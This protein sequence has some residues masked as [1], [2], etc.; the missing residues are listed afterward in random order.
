MRAVRGS[1][2]RRLSLS[3]D[4]ASQKS[5]LVNNVARWVVRDNVSQDHLKNTLTRF[6]NSDVQKGERVPFF[7]NCVRM[8]GAMNP[9]AADEFMRVAIE[10]FCSPD[11]IG[12]PDDPKHVRIFASAFDVLGAD[13][14]FDMIKKLRPVR[15]EHIRLVLAFFRAPRSKSAVFGNPDKCAAL[16]RR[17]SSHFGAGDFMTALVAER[18]IA[19]KACVMGDFV[20]AATRSF[21]FSSVD[22]AVRGGRIDMV[23]GSRHAPNGNTFLCYMD[24][25]QDD[26]F[27]KVV[28]DW[29]PLC[30]PEHAELALAEMAKHADE[31]VYTLDGRDRPMKHLSER[32]WE[33][34][35]DA[36]RRP[37]YNEVA[38]A[39]VKMGYTKLLGTLLQRRVFTPDALKLFTV[40]GIDREHAYAIN[41]LLSRHAWLAKTY[42]KDEMGVLQYVLHTGK[43]GLLDLANIIPELRSS[44]DV[45]DQ[46]GFTPLALALKK[47]FPTAFMRLLKLGAD[48]AFVHP[49]LGTVLH[50]V[51]ST[52]SGNLVW[53]ELLQWLRLSVEHRQRLP[54]LEIRDPVYN[55]TALQMAV[56]NGRMD[57]AVYLVLEGASLDTQ[58]GLCEGMSLLDYVFLEKNWDYVYLFHRLRGEEACVVRIA[59]RFLDG[60]LSGESLCDIFKLPGFGRKY[61]PGRPQPITYN[62]DEAA[63][64]LKILNGRAEFWNN[65]VATACGDTC[66]ICGDELMIGRY[67]TLCGHLFHAQCMFERLFSRNDCPVCGAVQTNKPVKWVPGEEMVP[68]PAPPAEN[69]VAVRTNDQPHT[70]LLIVNE[71]GMKRPYGTRVYLQFF[72]RQFLINGYWVDERD[73]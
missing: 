32:K 4:C 1:L 68:R 14:L 26:M 64:V 41:L 71:C 8:A 27:E 54:H 31:E 10:S 60:A 69:K 3:R 66:P 15:T 34:L 73:L 20:L 42:V 67:K 59:Y 46:S 25:L 43:V 6:Y 65:E 28:A 53:S 56:E 37:P 24:N 55:L 36:A 50:M 22:A 38:T 7:L 49:E 9:P 51:V 70:R 19:S 40:F 5:V 29:L 21:N 23:A 72:V 63:F 39:A 33:L 48:L 2:S 58:F 30:D 13:A 57:V 47:E 16:F 52:P 17:V 45:V 12:T 11:G 35:L 18:A 44:L 61:E 62:K